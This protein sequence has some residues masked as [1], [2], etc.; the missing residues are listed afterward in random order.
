MIKMQINKKYRKHL[1]RILSNEMLYAVL[2]EMKEMNEK[3][4]S[5]TEKVF[6]LICS[7]ILGGIILVCLV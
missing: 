7:G 4:D 1:I 3:E 2:S 5:E 6:K